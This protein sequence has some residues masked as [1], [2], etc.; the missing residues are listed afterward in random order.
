M[1]GTADVGLVL[2]AIIVLV[3]IIVSLIAHNRK[4]V[5][6]ARSWTPGQDWPK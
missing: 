2:L 3:I 5:R 4:K 1:F 6:Q